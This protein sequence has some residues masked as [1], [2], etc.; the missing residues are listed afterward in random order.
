MKLRRLSRDRRH[1]GQSLVEF[2]LVIPVFLLVVCG[3]FDLGSA[4]FSYTSITNA[5]REA[6][7]LAIVNQDQPSIENRALNQTLIAEKT[8]PNVT[9]HFYQAK[10][11]GTPNLAVPCTAPIAAGCLAVVT[12]EATYKPITPIIGDVLFPKG[13]TFKTTTI[14]TVEYSCPNATAAAVDCPKQP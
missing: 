10:S 2:A 4:V 1:R 14:V 6:A 5:S 11:D 9:V 3:I 7:R 12:F 13:V 8:A